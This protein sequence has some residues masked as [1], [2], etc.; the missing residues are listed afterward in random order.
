[1]A[2]LI[3]LGGCSVGFTDDQGRQ[4]RMGL[5]WTTTEAAPTRSAGQLVSVTTL[6]LAAVSLPSHAGLALG[7]SREVELSLGNDACVIRDI[8]W[9]MRR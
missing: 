9:M 3:L 6:G 1:M 2:T 4:H 8:G 5:M 7:Y